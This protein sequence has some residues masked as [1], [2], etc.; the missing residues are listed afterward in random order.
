VKTIVVALV[1]LSLFLTAGA[2]SAARPA[3]SKCHSDRSCK[4]GLCV[5]E[6]PEDKF[7]LCCKPRTCPE[8][9]AQCGVVDNGCG[10]ERN[11]GDCD[12][13]SDCESNQCVMTSTT[14]SS[15]EIPTTTTLPPPTTTVPTTTT[16][17]PPTTTTTEFP[18]TTTTV[19]TTTTTLPAESCTTGD[20]CVNGCC[21]VSDLGGYQC[22]DTCCLAC[23]WSCFDAC[24]CPSGPNCEYCMQGDSGWGCPQAACGC[25]IW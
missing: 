10:G 19:P 11:C 22:G 8:I 17:L 1:S 24:L 20:D 9:G 18:Q 5:R 13:G 21:D 6:N 23:W 7:G 3:A 15:T 16:T 14:T 2:A 12:P 25:P 4:T